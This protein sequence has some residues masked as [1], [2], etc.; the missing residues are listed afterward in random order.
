MIDVPNSSVNV[1]TSNSGVTPDFDQR[2][3]KKEEPESFEK[4]SFIQNA[5]KKMGS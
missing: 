5:F 3:L 2:Y 1:N 4:Y